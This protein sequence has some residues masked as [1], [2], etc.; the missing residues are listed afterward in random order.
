MASTTAPHCTA[1]LSL[2]PPSHRR[3]GVCIPG[4]PT[5]AD[6]RPA[7]FE[8]AVC[9]QTVSQCAASI[10]HRRFPILPTPAISLAIGEM[11]VDP[12]AAE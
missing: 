12:A 1:L 11:E 5:A 2:L 10:H 6:G 4:L 7:S 8:T 3:N 9:V